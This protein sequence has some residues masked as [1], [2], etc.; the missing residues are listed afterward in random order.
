MAGFAGHEFSGGCLC[1]AVRFRGRWTDAPATLCHCGQCR[2]WA[3]HAWASSTAAGMA[4]TGPVRW[5][6]SSDRAERGFCP[7]CGS[8]LFWREIGAV[9]TG[10]AAGAVDAPTGLTLTR[11]IFT[12]DK[13]DYYDI[14]DGLPQDPR[15]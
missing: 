9:E 10:V 15:E 11:H 5:F 13:G 4:V 12:A 2:R 8:S 6:R 1:G 3:G 7:D 14:A